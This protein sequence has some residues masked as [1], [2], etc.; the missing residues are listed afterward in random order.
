MI[1]PQTAQAVRD[2]GLRVDVESSEASVPALVAALA[3]FALVRRAEAEA[4]GETNVVPMPKG[5]R[6]R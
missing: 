4:R 3:E 2:Q 1:G 5:R 6:K